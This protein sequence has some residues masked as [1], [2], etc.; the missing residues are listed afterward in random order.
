MTVYYLQFDSSPRHGGH[1][2]PYAHCSGGGYIL[3]GG[4]IYYLDN[5]YRGGV[6]I[7]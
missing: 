2:L 3:Y 5:R 6:S 1:F 7:I 4:G